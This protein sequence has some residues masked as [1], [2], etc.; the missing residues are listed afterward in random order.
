MR[1]YRVIVDEMAGKAR[2]LNINID[3][4][5]SCHGRAQ[6]L[7]FI[8]KNF[9]LLYTFRLVTL[10]L[11]HEMYSEEDLNR[12][13]IYTYGE[14]KGGYFGDT[15]IACGEAD[16]TVNDCKVFAYG[17]SSV[18]CLSGSTC[19]ARGNVCVYCS[20]HSDVIAMGR[21]NIKCEGYSVV[22]VSG[23]CT[24]EAGGY[25]RVFINGGCTVKAGDCSWVYSRDTIDD[26]IYGNTTVEACD[27]ATVLCDSKTIVSIDN[28]GYCSSVNFTEGTINASGLLH[29]K[30]KD[31][32]TRKC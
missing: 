2:K 30:S 18:N 13:G 21:C 23:G 14:F 9:D 29:Y 3:G 4:L 28:L 5:F 27:Y 22:H 1:K 26:C 19:V 6:L 31:G 8:K 11:L 7:L 20:G 12:Q 10:D 24:V 15:V 25:S 16:V 32:M 17:D